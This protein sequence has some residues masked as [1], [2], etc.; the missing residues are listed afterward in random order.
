MDEHIPAATL[1]LF[2]DRELP[3]A[4][5]HRVERHLSA[6]WRCRAELEALQQT[7]RLIVAAQDGML[8][9]AVTRPP[10]VW[11]NLNPRFDAADEI[12]KRRIRLARFLAFL[13]A[14]LRLPGRAAAVLTC[15]MCVF[16]LAWWLRP[17]RLSAQE[18]L[19]RAE[20]HSRA[21]RQTVVHQRLRVSEQLPAPWRGRAADLEVWSGQAGTQLKATDD[22]ILASLQKMCAANGL[23]VKSL[24]APAQ[25]RRW[26]QERRA[27]LAAR[28]VEDGFVLSASA[29][30][31]NRTD[32]ATESILRT[33]I[34]VRKADWHAT[35]V[36]M[37]LADRVFEAAELSY[38]ELPSAEVPAGLFQENAPG[39]EHMARV[40]PPRTGGSPHTAPPVDLD[41]LEL[42]VR[43]TLHAWGAD[44]G[45]PIEVIR[46]PGLPLVVQALG[47]TP[48]RLR[49]LETLSREMPGLLLDT[50]GRFN[51]PA[52]A[53]P[54]SDE[55]LPP[56][57]PRTNE[58]DLRVRQYFG[59]REAQA[60][61]TTD[62]LS[63]MD[64]VLARTYALETL[65]RRWRPAQEAALSVDSKR[66]LRNL[67][68]DH[69]VALGENA[70]AFRQLA[71]PLILDLGGS[72]DEIAAPRATNWQRSAADA[73]KAARRTDTLL[74]SLLTHTD[75]HYSLE[76]TLRGLSRSLASLGAASEQLSTGTERNLF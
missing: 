18:I 35:L 54:P 66:Q 56:I 76:D 8:S 31:G 67:V 72:L 60:H 20:H 27:A 40:M 29:G 33:E 69:C 25:F 13:A 42:R 19:E 65:A 73:L 11:A 6:C 30:E 2:V 45:E 10:R 15:G 17:E 52:P 22:Q 24:L 4:D 70:A 26:Q 68:R 51:S 58:D 7:I 64:K 9:S 1:L 23:A 49:Q 46:R 37:E 5:S 53:E 36:R 50:S 3:R 59:S 61:G 57:V 75:D 71:T 48:Q 38:H 44:L 63:A 12:A 43:A 62:L 16:V 32:A 74:R 14:P 39:A 41:A 34:T 28:T 47:S 55:G 21:A